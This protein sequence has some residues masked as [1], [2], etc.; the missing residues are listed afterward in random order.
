DAANVKAA[1]LRSEKAVAD[2]DWVLTFVLRLLQGMDI[3]ALAVDRE[4]EA[5]RQEEIFGR[6][7][8][9][10]QIFD[11]AAQ[12]GKILAKD[13]ALAARRTD[14]VGRVIGKRITDRGS[15]PLSE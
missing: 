5:L 12:S 6:V 11:V 7:Q 10:P 14:A 2:A 15:D 1:Q 9:A 8:A 13:D 4:D 3:A